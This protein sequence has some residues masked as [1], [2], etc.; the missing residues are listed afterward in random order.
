MDSILKAL[1]HIDLFRADSLRI[2]IAGIE[3][4]SIGLKRDQS[5]DFLDGLKIGGELLFAA[6]LIKRRAS[7]IDEIV[8]AAGILSALP[9]IL[10]EDEYVENLSLGAGNTGKGFDLE[11]N[12]RIA[13]FTFIQWQGGPEVIRQNKIF[14]DFFFL[15]EAETSKV[16]ELYTLGLDHPLKFFNSGRSLA[17]IL[18]GNSKL[19]RAFQEKHGKMF[20]KVKDYFAVKSSMVRIRDIRECV[21]FLNEIPEVC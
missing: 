17:R 10:D 4:K 8:H 11:T 7:Q 13:E 15:A 3:R 21:P 6:F 9:Y 20:P 2:T 19:G 14:K 1:D 5:V 12:K 18:E 16:R